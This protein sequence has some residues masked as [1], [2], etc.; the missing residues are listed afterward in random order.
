M[1]DSAAWFWISKKVKNKTK[2]SPVKQSVC[3]TLK[4][5][6]CFE[7]TNYHFENVF[8]FDL[9]K[10]TLTTQMKWNEQQCVV[11]EG[12]ADILIDV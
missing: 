2:K 3:V 11:S 1:S 7:P 5:V 4:L 8:L 6:H 9:F 12:I 10:S